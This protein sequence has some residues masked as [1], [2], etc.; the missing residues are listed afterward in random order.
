MIEEEL[1]VEEDD[2]IVDMAHETKHEEEQEKEEHTSLQEADPPLQ[3][4]I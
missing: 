2:S 3:K 1:S 4:H